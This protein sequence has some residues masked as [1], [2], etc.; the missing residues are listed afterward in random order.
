MSNYEKK[1][2]N[3]NTVCA[4]NSSYPNIDHLTLFIYFC[5]LIKAIQVYKTTEEI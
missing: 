4:V 5:S 1:N 3:H 2:N